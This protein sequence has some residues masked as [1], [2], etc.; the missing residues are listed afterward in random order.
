MSKPNLQSV[1]K[2]THQI[3]QL[4]H[5][6]QGLTQMWRDFQLSEDIGGDLYGAITFIKLAEQAL[7]EKRG[8]LLVPVEARA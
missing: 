7:S 4:E 8:K 1:E 2:L 3:N 5:V 6:R